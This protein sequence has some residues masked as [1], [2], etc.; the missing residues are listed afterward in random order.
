MSHEY[1]FLLAKRGRYYFDQDAVREPQSQLTLERFPPGKRTRKIM[2]KERVASAHHP[3]VRANV[4][5]KTSTSH[6]IV[7]GVRN[8]RSVWTIPPVPSP[9]P[10]FATFPEE[11]AR[12]CI[13]AGCPPGGVVLDPFAGTGTTL[14]AAR[15]LGRRAVGIEL[16]AD[17]VRLAS[18]RLR[19][20]V[21]GARAITQGQAPLVE[22]P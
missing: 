12:R 21:R 14:K 4:S 20:G 8:M 11:L 19:Y 16:S 15:D 2:P 6:A 18:D 3:E 1:V 22:T 9:L 7:P 13:L 5:F 10:H 17:Y